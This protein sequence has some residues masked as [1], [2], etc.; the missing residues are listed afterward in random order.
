MN[1]RRVAVV[2][3]VLLVVCACAIVW[4]VV[5]AT[6]GGFVLR[7]GPLRISSRT[8]R[9]P[10]LIALASALATWA[11]FRPDVRQN[12]RHELL[13][14]KES[15]FAFGRFLR[16]Q[17]RWLQWS[18]AGAVLIAA[19]VVAVREWAEGSPL[20]LDEEMIALNIRDRSLA[21]LAGPLWFGQSAPLGWLALERA[22]LVAFGTSEMALRALP[23]LF[24]VATLCTAAWVAWRWMGP[25]GAT[26]LLLL[27]MFGQALSFFSLDLKHYSADAFWGLLLPALGAWALES[28]S[29]ESMWRSSRLIVWWAAAAV[30]QWFA[31]GAL[32]VTPACALV[33]VIVVHRRSG[34]RGAAM[35][36]LCAVAWLVSFGINYWLALRHAIGSGYLRDYWAFAMAPASPPLD[37]VAWLA[38]Q[39]APLADTAGGTSLWVMF[40]IAVAGGFVLSTSARLGVLLALVP[41][42]AFV[43]A[44]LRLVPL[45]ERL[46]LWTVPA[47]YAGVALF[48]DSGIRLARA[49]RE[50]RSGLRRAAAVVVATIGLGVCFD[51]VLRGYG[52]GG[53]RTP[54]SNRGF[55]DRNAVTWLMAQRQRGDVLMTTRL[56]LPAVWWYGRVPISD[57]SSILEVGY[58]SRELECAAGRVRD[59]LKNERRVLVHLGFKDTPEHFDEWLFGDLGELGQLADRREFGLFNRAAI[60]DLRTPPRTP[61][62]TLSNTANDGCIVAQ[63]ATRW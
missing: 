37:R 34:W 63:P 46:S 29:R 7:L 62:T 36:A 12:V 15:A 14:W 33:F 2:R 40:W 8:P 53:A 26:V 27:C 1:S 3:R 5:L 56:A 57:A 4:A 23:L 58:T 55:D 48:A 17:W 60:F 24:T 28:R 61:R 50:R 10:V 39:L 16:R 20:W 21:E 19:C 52:G 38:R 49:A 25:V 47:L 59:L 31:N 54:E 11:L 43:L 45:Y 42:S 13:C 35:V 51:I 32:L 41:L 18:P 6:S 44:T 22:A 9:N 30:G